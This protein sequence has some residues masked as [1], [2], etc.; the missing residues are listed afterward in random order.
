MF[1]VF[2]MTDEELK[3]ANAEIAAELQKRET[4]E[5]GKLWKSFVDALC[6]YCKKF[7]DIELHDG[8]TIYLNS[9]DFD[10]QNFGEIYPRY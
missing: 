3:I 9:N 6:A 5:Q 7:G 8:C 4:M 1:D 2:R 10:L